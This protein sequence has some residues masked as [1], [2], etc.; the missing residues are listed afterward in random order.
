MKKIIIL[1]LA[2]LLVS[3][4]VSAE[5]SISETLEGVDQYYHLVLAEEAVG[6]DTA[7]ATDIVLGL[8]KH[9]ELEINTV[10]DG[11][12]SDALPKIYIGPYCGSSYLESVFGY[13]CEEWPYEENQAIVKVDGNNLIITG[14]SPT[15]R[16]MAGV[17]LREYPD[18]QSL[19]DYSFI[20]ILGD[21]LTP[22]ELTIEEAKEEDEFI[23]GDGVCEPGE[24][25][26]CF[27]DCNKKTCNDI[28][29]EEGFATSY[30]REVP[31][32]PNVKI[33][34]PGESNKG[35]RYCTGEKSCCCKPEEKEE[36][37][38]IDE[39]IKEEATQELGF[40]EEFFSKEDAA[41]SVVFTLLAIVIII[42]GIW[43]ILSR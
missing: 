10:I 42:L 35:L 9:N 43:F 20:I 6:G 41:R 25:F 30:C 28:C 22:A 17:I 29:K 38:F 27:P 24:S 1:F 5:K 12:I 21:T 2:V 7:A 8:Q 33:C 16:R 14:T 19:K 34:E 4:L 23:C 37:V 15:D 18:Y 31:T 39:P 32:N 11:E 36:T 3:Q 40:F 13:S 26:L